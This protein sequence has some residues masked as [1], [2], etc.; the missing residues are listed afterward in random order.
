[1]GIIKWGGW[2]LAMGLLA[3]SSYAQD[4]LDLAQAEQQLRSGQGEQ[5]Y[6]TLLTHESDQ[7]G[8]PDFTRRL[9]IDLPALG[10][11]EKDP[12]GCATVDPEFALIDLFD[13]LDQ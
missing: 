1:M 12:A 5:A 4:T 11:M 2:V 9:V 10:E 8:N 6:Q 13:G 7:A 3:H